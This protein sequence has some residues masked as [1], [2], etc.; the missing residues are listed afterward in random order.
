VLS[1]ERTDGPPAAEP[2]SPRAR[3]Y[4]LYRLYRRPAPWAGGLRVP[5]VCWVVTRLLTVGAAL[6]GAGGSG[7]EVH[8]LYPAWAAELA[9]GHFP[10][11][12]T[13]WQY[14]P[15]AGLVFLAPRALPFL[16]YATAFALLMLLCDAV[17][18]ALLARA[19][20][21]PDRVNHGLWLWTLGLPLL[22]QL[23]YIRFD[24]AVTALAVGGVLL[25][26][27]SPVGGGALAALGG[28]VKAWPVLVLVGAPRGR[29]T[30]RSWTSAVVTA[31]LASGVLALAFSHAFSFLSEQGSRGV[32][33]ESLPGSLLLAARRFGY[34]GGIHYRYGSFQVGGSG[35]DAIATALLALTVLGFGWL[36]WWRLRARHW[37]PATAADAALTAML[38]FVTTS[39]VISPQYLVWLIGLGAVCLAFRASSQRPVA[40]ALL[41]LTVLTTLVYPVLWQPLLHGQALATALLLLRDAGLLAVTLWSARRLWQ[42]TR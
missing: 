14:P 2:A 3:W 33:I 18:T 7:D 25:L 28:L 23:P 35:V 31:L 17:V 27:R 41:P 15:V 30:R 22:F 1:S 20:R 9:H 8:V 19:A 4:R 38:V 5:L 10:F 21:G 37:G 24:V 26:D 39:R 40:L 12:D 36:L 6:A 42:A 11:H 16:G 29:T 34:H 32:E 13:Q